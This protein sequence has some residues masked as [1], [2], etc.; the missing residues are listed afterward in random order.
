MSKYKA[1]NEVVVNDKVVAAGE[2]IELDDKELN[3]IVKV[4]SLE[5]VESER[6][7]KKVK[8]KKVKE[9]KEN[10]SSI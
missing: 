3:K 8:Q 1:I 7:P 5:L 4:C 2:I 9:E 10:G 6:K